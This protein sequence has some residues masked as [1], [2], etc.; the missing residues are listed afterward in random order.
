ME[1]KTKL[2]RLKDFWN[3]FKEGSS[4]KKFLIIFTILCF[5]VP[6]AMVRNPAEIGSHVLP[7]WLCYY[8]VAG[9][10]CYNG[11]EFWRTFLAC[12]GIASLGI[13][14]IYTGTAGILYFVSKWKWLSKIKSKFFKNRQ[15]NNQTNKE[16]RKT[17]LSEWLSRQSVWVILLFLLIPFPY[18]DPAATVAMKL[19]NV[20]NGLWY[21]LA[22]NTLHV[23][24]IVL[25][26]YS[27][28]NLLVS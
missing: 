16:N 21:L 28:I 18:T 26:V 9:F 3:N 27:G 25:C 5:L 2:E 4:E 12:Y 24:I 6:F 15:T 8:G 19:K 14:F 17:R 22:V 13:I 7:L 20:K 11:M 1:E 23:F 10:W